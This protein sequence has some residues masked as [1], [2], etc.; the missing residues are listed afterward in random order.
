MTDIVERLRNSCS[1]NFP[2]TPCGAEDEC[3]AAFDA[4]DEIE[5][6][7]SALPEGMEHCKIIFEE[8]EVGHGR[9]RGD[10]WLKTECPW[11][12][13]KEQ[14]AEIE[15]LRAALEDIAYP[16]PLHNEDDLMGIARAALEGK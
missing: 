16:N 13:I 5:R 9:L 8:C 7:R 2:D 6:L 11:C 4:A 3:R 1:C 10:N 14:A 15:R 12:K